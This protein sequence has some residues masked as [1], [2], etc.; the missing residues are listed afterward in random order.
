MSDM[1]SKAKEDLILQS[2]IIMI[3]LSVPGQEDSGTTIDVLQSI[4]IMIDLSVPGQED[5]S[6]TNDVLQSIIIMIGLSVPGARRTVVPQM[7]CC[8]HK[9]SLNL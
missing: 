6:T 2:I 9:S 5:R 7:M 4:I 1:I 3:G 8:P